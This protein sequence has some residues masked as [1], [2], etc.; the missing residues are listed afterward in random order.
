MSLYA[1]IA[2]VAYTIGVVSGYFLKVVLDR[3]QK[4][5]VSGEVVLLV[6]TAGWLISVIYDIYS[7]TYETSPFIHALMGAIV[8]FYY[9]PRKEH[10]APYSF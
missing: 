4:I 1:F 8:G 6:V 9:K 10:D 7:T 2:L 3:M 5:N